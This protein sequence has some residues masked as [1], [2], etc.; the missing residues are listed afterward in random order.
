MSIALS[1][2]HRT[3]RNRRPRLHYPPINSELLYFG[4]EIKVGKLRFPFYQAFT[5]YIFVLESKLRQHFRRHSYPKFIISKFL[6]L[7]NLCHCI[8]QFCH[9]FLVVWLRLPPSQI[10]NLP[11]F[12]QNPAGSKVFTRCWIST[13]L[14]GD[15]QVQTVVACH[16]IQRGEYYRPGVIKYWSACHQKS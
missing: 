7:L 5:G 16:N 3:A 15:E 4:F 14:C 1:F 6:V 9:E 13:S 10:H 2:P 12:F 11:W 8:Q